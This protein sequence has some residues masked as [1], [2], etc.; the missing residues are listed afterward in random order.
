[1]TANPGAFKYSSFS[2]GD[3]KERF[4]WKKRMEWL[5]KD[6]PWPP[7]GKTLTMTYKADD[8][9]INTL[10][11]EMHS[12]RNRTVLMEDKFT[13]LSPNWEIYRGK[14]VNVAAKI[15]EYDLV[16]DYYVSRIND[17]KT[18]FQISQITFVKDKILNELIGDRSKLPIKLTINQSAAPLFLVR[19]Y[20]IL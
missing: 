15:D 13:V 18:W 4:Q 7:A 3:I 12:D 10:L 16:P 6:M 9:T 1:M 20:Q 19:K 8:Q 17:I 5:P 2:I 14:V 11:G